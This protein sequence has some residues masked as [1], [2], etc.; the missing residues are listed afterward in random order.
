MRAPR[1]NS[2]PHGLKNKS[3]ETVIAGKEWLTFGKRV[4][5]A[6]QHAFDHGL[7]RKMQEDSFAKGFRP[8]QR[9]FGILQRALD[10]I[11]HG[12]GDIGGKQRLGVRSE[13]LGDAADIR[14]H[15]RDS[16]RGGLDH[17]I[18]HRIPAR[19]NHQQSALG[20]AVTRLDVAEEADRVG[21]TEPLDLSLEIFEFLAV[22]GQGQRYQLAVGA[23]PRHR[24]DQEVGALDV[25]ELADIDDIAGVGCPDDRIEFVGGYAVENAAHKSFGDADGALIG[26]ARKSA[27]EQEQVG[28]VH[29]RA[30][31]AA[32]DLPLEGGQRK[33]Q[34]AAVGGVD[35]NGARRAALQTN[36]GAGLGAVTVQHV[37]LQTPD[38]P[39]EVRPYQRIG[40]KQLAADSEPMDAE[41]EPRRNLV[42]RRLGAFAAGEAIGDYADMVAAVGLAVGKIEDVPE[43]SA[44]RRAHRVQDTKRLIWNRGHDQNQRSPTSTVSPGPSAVPS[45]TTIRIGPEA[46]A[47]VSVTLSRRARGEKPPAIA[48]ALST[49]IFGT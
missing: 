8:R 46:S 24:I 39:H 15:H 38:Q 14:R 35:P 27:F 29:Q 10:R 34:R 16:R 11:G 1:R 33:M 48:T 5:V 22:S 18:G 42:K 12:A 44:D 30:F 45:G 9:G 43:D 6:G 31:K 2:P 17:N 26:I 13:N 20:K 21:E 49:L 40:R 47:W 32:I 36:E 23:Q 41:L 25:P 37:G 7:L 28:G 3:E 4:A 19:R